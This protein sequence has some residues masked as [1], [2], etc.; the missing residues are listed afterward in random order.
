AAASD[1]GQRGGD[2]DAAL[3]G[4]LAGEQ[5]QVLEKGH[6]SAEEPETRRQKRTCAKPSARS[7]TH[8]LLHPGRT[9]GQP[10]SVAL[11][12]RG[13]IPRRQGGARSQGAGPFGMDLG[14]RPKIGEFEVSA[15]REWSASFAR[16]IHVG[17]R[18]IRVPAPCA[19]LRKS[20]VG[21]EGRG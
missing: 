1:A 8:S 15:A 19:R 6:G 21:Q 2:L 18:R 9:R 14:T 12:R 17:R 13:R 11:C 10:W 5:R 3:P 4:E 20:R 16:S 7:R